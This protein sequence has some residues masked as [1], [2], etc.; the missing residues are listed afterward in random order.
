MIKYFR[1]NP[2]ADH[3][4]LEEILDGRVAT[5]KFAR[6]STQE[7]EFEHSEDDAEEEG[8]EGEEEEEKEEEEEDEEVAGPS[9]SV[10]TVSTVTT[11]S[12][13]TPGKPKRKPPPPTKA[14]DIL[15]K[16]ASEL[17]KKPPMEQVIDDLTKTNWFDIEY[18]GLQKL[19]IVRAIDDSTA[20]LYLS[21]TSV[22]DKKDI[23]QQL[24]DD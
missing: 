20:L 1:K 2:L 15:T 11:K 10:T 21:L 8:E 5:G 4:E 18:S 23:I 13:V 22:E 3:N 12:S 9:S 14:V 17:G 24:S 19:R 7:K 6:S 16:I